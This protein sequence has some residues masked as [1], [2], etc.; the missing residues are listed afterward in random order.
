MASPLSP[1]P[2]ACTAQLSLLEGG[3]W[4]PC[5]AASGLIL[6]SPTSHLLRCGR[7][8]W[9]SKLSAVVGSLEAWAEKTSQPPEITHVWMDALC[10]NQHRIQPPASPGTVANLFGERIEAVG[11]AVV[12]L[13]HA[14]RPLYF[15]RA[16]CLLEF[17]VA[18]QARAS[19]AISVAYPADEL[20]ALDSRLARGEL[21]SLSNLL[22]SP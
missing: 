2:Y 8:A 1:L 22:Q 12:L 4:R 18:I 13:D 9:G 7:Y 14:I 16:W 17:F 6:C 21:I 3:W 11:A 20:R 15:E 5:A 10:E 19:V